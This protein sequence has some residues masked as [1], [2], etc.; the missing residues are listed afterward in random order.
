M[1]EEIK[2]ENLIEENRSSTQGTIN[3]E[4]LYERLLSILHSKETLLKESEIKKNSIFDFINNN[5]D[6]EGSAFNKFLTEL[7]EKKLEDEKINL[8]NESLNEAIQY[9]LNNMKIVN[10]NGIIPG[11]DYTYGDLFQADA[12][13]SFDESKEKEWVRPWKNIN[14]IDYSQVRSGDA[15]KSVLN[16][17]ENLQFTNSNREKDYIRLLMPMYERNV[18]IEDLDRNFWVIGQVITGI[19]KYIFDNGPITKEF[20]NLLKEVGEIWENILFLWAALALQKNRQYENVHTEVVYLPNDEYQPNMKYD[21]FTYSI[22]NSGVSW[23]DVCLRLEPYKQMYSDSNLALIIVRRIENYQHNYYKTE[24]FSGIAFYDR[25]N[26]NKNLNGFR[27]LGFKETD[28]DGSVTNLDIG[29]NTAINN[30]NST[31]G[32]Y[33]CCI[34]ETSVLKNNYYMPYSNVSNFAT[35][36]KTTYYGAIRTIVPY[37]DNMITYNIGTG[38]FI[39]HKDLFSI[40]LY[41]AIGNSVKDTTTDKLLNTQRIGYFKYSKDQIIGKDDISVKY[42]NLPVATV[43]TKLTEKSGNGIIDSGYYLGELISQRKNS[44]VFNYELHERNIEIT[45]INASFE[46]IM[47]SKAM[48]AIKED[49]DKILN[50]LIDL[51][52]LSD[53]DSSKE[54]EFCLYRGTR[55][56]DLFKAEDRNSTQ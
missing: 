23:N 13:N 10:S 37:R 7:S 16:S 43:G 3:I 28:N 33:A 50:S 17:N 21:N 14:K 39:L 51:K 31:W 25:N 18:E 15:I 11:T 32:D 53:N 9:Y 24:R 48:A 8:W 46:K 6:L 40:E 55:R 44:K 54:P 5:A 4:G 56:F 42:I 29:L 52:V 27:V 34:H 22:N 36:K 45:P 12:G 19:C 41:D 20:E 2:L 35:E 47:N 38:D 30:S 49:N 26:P 1:A